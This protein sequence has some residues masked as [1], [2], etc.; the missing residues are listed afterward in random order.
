MSVPDQTTD[1]AT[2]PASDAAA[3][4][5]RRK[6][7]KPIESTVPRAFYRR[8]DVERRTSLPTQTIYRLMRDGRFPRPVQL[9]ERSVAWRV[10]EIEAWVA[11]R[12]GEQ[13]DDTAA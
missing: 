2:A 6:A 12:D 4:P 7:R 10:A 5:K 13:P 9:T 8:R 11:K 1:Q 3:Q